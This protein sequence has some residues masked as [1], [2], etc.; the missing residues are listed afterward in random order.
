MRLA[1]RTVPLGLLALVAALPLSSPTSTLAAAPG[2]APAAAVCEGGEVAVAGGLEVRAKPGAKVAEPRADRG[3][4]DLL[5]GKPTAGARN[6]GSITVPVAFHVVQASATEGALTDA[7]VKRQLAVLNQAYAGKARPTVT[8]PVTPVPSARTPFRF[9]L[10]SIDRTVNPAW[11]SFLPSSKAE[12]DAKAALHV[13]GKET[14]NV[15]LTGLGGG[16]LGYAYFPTTGQ[17]KDLLDGVVVLNDSIPAGGA[18]NYQEGDTLPHEV[19]HW[20]GLYHTFQNGCST[21]GDRVS[22]TPAEASPNFGCPE[23]VRDTCTDPGVDPTTNYMDYSYDACMYA[24]T[25][26]QADRM[27]AVW[28]RYRAPR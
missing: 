6:T 23:A 2:A 28:E 15:Y 1:L 26:G 18:K 21:A 17:G 13:G 27:T 4:Q 5:Q 12:R 19:G 20:L 8:G 22:D 7:Q 24:F 10:R 9:S 16:L 11:Y 14:L 25:A 3:G